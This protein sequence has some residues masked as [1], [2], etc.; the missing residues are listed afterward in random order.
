MLPKMHVSWVM[1]EWKG[2]FICR[3]MDPFSLTIWK[4]KKNSIH[5]INEC[6]FFS[7]QTPVAV[8][9]WHVR[10][11]LLWSN[12]TFCQMNVVVRTSIVL[13]RLPSC[14]RSPCGIA[15]PNVRQCTVN[16]PIRISALTC[17]VHSS[18]SYRWV[19]YR[20]LSYKG[21]IYMHSVDG[22]QKLHM[23]MSKLDCYRMYRF[24]FTGTYVCT[25]RWLPLCSRWAYSST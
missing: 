20:L 22:Q 25:A 2:W 5:A 15:M 16:S 8:L 13:V 21:K 9:R 12:R 11:A 3:T 4:S 24:W 18:C 23:K 7:Q 17:F 14:Y 19:C 10:R 6:L 1:F